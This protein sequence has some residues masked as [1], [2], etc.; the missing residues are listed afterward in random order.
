MDPFFC[1]LLKKSQKRRLRKDRDD[2]E[3]PC[4]AV[5][6]GHRFAKVVAI[7]DGTRGF[8]SQTSPARGPIWTNRLVFYESRRLLP[9]WQPTDLNLGSRRLA[10]PVYARSE[11]VLRDSCDSVFLS[12]PEDGLMARRGAMGCSQARAL[13]GRL[14]ARG[15]LL[16]HRR[17]AVGRGRVVLFRIFGHF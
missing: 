11:R 16:C 1:A 8:V 10:A 9:G 13:A 7:L 6:S 15:V 5:F 17:P 2:R 12:G 14:D 4:Y 3:S